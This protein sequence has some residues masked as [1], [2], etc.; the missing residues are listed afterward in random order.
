MVSGKGNH[1]K[2]SH[3]AWNKGL[4]GRQPWHNTSGLGINIDFAQRGQSI[5]LSMMGMKRPDAYK[6]ERSKL[7]KEKWADP[8]YRMKQQKAMKNG[9]TGGWNKGKE[10]PQLAGKNS[11]LW[12]GG[13][14]TEIK[15]IRNSVKYKSWRTAVFER[16]NYT[17]RGCGQK[18]VFLEAHH[19]KSFSDY[20]NAR[21]LVDNGITYCQSCHAK[22]DQ[23]R[24]RTLKKTIKNNLI[25]Q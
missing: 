21:F 5:S 14:T 2:K 23:Q 12:K 18:G 8:E 3:P 1:P 25:H 19:I 7:M 22:N 11:H 6:E 16:D 9:N 13:I 4:K 15:K 24:M 10:M 17:C 20:P